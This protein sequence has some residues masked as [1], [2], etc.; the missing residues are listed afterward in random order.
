MST[1]KT[2]FP[3]FH[4]HLK[5]LQK[6][7]NDI[8][9]NIVSGMDWQ[10]QDL[11]YSSMENTPNQSQKKNQTMLS[12]VV[13]NEITYLRDVCFLINIYSTFS[14]FRVQIWDMLI[15]DVHFHIPGS[16]VCERR[17]DWENQGED[18]RGQQSYRCFGHKERTAKIWW[19]DF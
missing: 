18:R 19:A 5:K 2:R 4:N 11:F 16:K 15:W 9:P 10:S 7:V 6:T 17:G 1:D 14:I 8:C 3:H 13:Y 12:T